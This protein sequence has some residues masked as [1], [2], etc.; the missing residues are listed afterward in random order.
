MTK[1]PCPFSSNK[2]TMNVKLK[3]VNIKLHKL[4][5]ISKDTVMMLNQF[6]QKSCPNTAGS[7]GHLLMGVAFLN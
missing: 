5:N 4:I 7:F 3:I 2:Q 6:P 1:H